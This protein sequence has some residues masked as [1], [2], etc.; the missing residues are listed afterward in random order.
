[1]SKTERR[2][3]SL[4]ERFDKRRVE[5]WGFT[6][7]TLLLQYGKYCIGKIVQLFTMSPMLMAQMV[8]ATD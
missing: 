6:F 1:M 8:R 7:P 3:A 2:H 5:K 4:D